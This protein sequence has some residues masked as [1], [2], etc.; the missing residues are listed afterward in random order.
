MAQL[1]PPRDEPVKVLVADS[2]L[3]VLH[4]LKL[5]LERR[6]FGVVTSTRPAD[7]ALVL[8]EQPAD[9]GVI[10][11]GEPFG[12]DV[13]YAIRQMSN[14]LD[15][16]L[17]ALLPP[18]EDSQIAVAIEEGADDAMMKPIS[19][20]E[21]LARVEAK[22][23]R[24]PRATTVLHFDGLRIDI[25]RR[26]VTVGDGPVDLPPREFDLLV[27]LAMRPNEVV[28]RERILEDLWG[29]SLSWQSDDT[30]TEHIHRL[31]RRIERAPERPRWVHTARGVGYR[32]CPGSDA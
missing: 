18:A 6:G 8:A 13:I 15:I 14:P 30:L 26:E 21:L 31:R 10:Q 17:L 9:I 12:F 20:R 27:Y 25:L 23:R 3:A 24:L 2:D 22:A 1:L 19:P 4:L 32:F 7:A 28:A 16:W 11:V 5:P 29:S